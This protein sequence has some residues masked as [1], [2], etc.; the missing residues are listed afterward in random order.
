M[1]DLWIKALNNVAEIIVVELQTELIQQG[2]N[3]TGSLVKSIEYKVDQEKDA[4][5]YAFMYNDYG[6]F[7]N[8][9]VKAAN[10]PYGGK[11][12]NGGTSLYIQG[13]I[14]FV[15]KLGVTGEKESKSFAFGIAAKHKKEG[16]PTKSSYK[17]SRNGRRTMFQGQVILKIEKQIPSLIDKYLFGEIETVFSEMVN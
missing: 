10:I 3:L 1:L 15:K 11:R 8:R 4:L 5:I 6:K 12:G 9:G 14:D 2:H 17:F 13:L 7:V 16:M